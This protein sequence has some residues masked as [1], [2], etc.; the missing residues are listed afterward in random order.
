MIAQLI[1][2]QKKKKK[3][4]KLKWMIARFFNRFF[5]NLWKDIVSM[6]QNFPLHIFSH[7]TSK[8]RDL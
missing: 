4:K 6:K 1:Q 5:E 7:I 2:L 3:K 8:F